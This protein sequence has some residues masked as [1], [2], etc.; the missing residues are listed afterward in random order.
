MKPAV[1]ER[2]ARRAAFRRMSR[3]GKL[4]YLLAYYKLPLALGLGAVLV[5]ASVL[6]HAAARREALLYV[7]Y[8]NV[9]VGDSL[10]T[11]LSEGFVDAA[12]ADPKQYRVYTY[13]GLYLSEAPAAENHAYSYASRLKVLAAVDAKQLDAVLMNREAYD[14][15]SRSGY[16]LPLPPLLAEHDPAVYA[17]LAGCLTENDVVLEDN[18][19]EYRLNEADSYTEVTE[20]SLNAIEITDFPLVRDA[21]FPEAV[22]LGVIAN[23]ERLPACLA[24]IEYLRGAGA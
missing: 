6:A 2:R 7:A 15:F 8:V 1:Q 23:S 16:L 14:I 3:R 19:L 12:G 13:T 11:R 18:A 4:E 21:G 20:R 5:L 10:Q 22:Y 9:S 24:Y 17:R